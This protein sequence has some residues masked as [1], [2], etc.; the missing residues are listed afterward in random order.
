MI[1]PFSFWKMFTR[2]EST[3]CP[4]GNIYGIQYFELLRK[5]RSIVFRIRFQTTKLNTSP[6]PFEHYLPVLMPGKTE[7]T[8]FNRTQ[9]HAWTDQKSAINEHINT[10]PAW[11]HITG[12]FE[13]ETEEG[14]RL[15]RTGASFEKKNTSL[16]WSVLR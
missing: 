6:K 16:I 14:L 13:I 10:C 11:K 8:L 2:G 3:L 1:F 9:E 5:D 15:N 7:S 4:K 12:L